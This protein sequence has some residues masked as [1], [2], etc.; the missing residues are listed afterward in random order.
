MRILLYTTGNVFSNARTGGMKRFVEL[1]KYINANFENVD[2]CSMDSIEIM[3]DNKFKECYSLERPLNTRLKKL[4]PELAI[5]L[6][7]KKTIRQLKKKEYSLVIVFDVPTAIG[8]CLMGFHNIVLMLRKDMIGYEVVNTKKKGLKFFLKIA[9]QWF[10]ES[11]CFY[12]SRLILTQCSYDL[13]CICKRHPLLSKLIKSKTKIQINNVNPS[14]LAGNP[15]LVQRIEPP[16]FRICFIG[17]FN[18][19]RKGHGLLLPV[20]CKLQKVHANIELVVIG[21]GIQ[22]DEYKEKYKS[23]KSI[24]FLGRHNKP[25]VELVKCNLLVV[26]SYADSCPNTVMEALYN[27][28]PVIGSRAGGIPEILGNDDALFD[29]TQASLYQKLDELI[30]NPSQLANL[31]DMEEKRSFELTFNWSE[32]IMNL[33]DIKK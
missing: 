22:L 8:L 3:K 5:L 14:W 23:N 32:R 13:S 15:P 29:L 26:P 31:K 12:R 6:R 17:D 4:I 18:S 11:I 19:D 30:S 10:C 33:I 27:H 28:I 1:S 9:M 21:D 20:F 7:N 24:T 16:T 2:L 25:V